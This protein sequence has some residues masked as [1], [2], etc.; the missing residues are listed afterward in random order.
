[1]VEELDILLKNMK[2]NLLDLALE[3]L[4]SIE[5]KGFKAF[6]VGGAVRDYLMGNILNIT[7]VDICSNI[8]DITLNQLFDVKQELYKSYKILFKNSKAN[9]TDK[10][11]TTFLPKLPKYFVI[12]Y[13]VP[14]T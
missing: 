14:F 7:D 5:S 6:I 3:I 2:N 1:M 9:V 11:L 4:D 8:D 10:F 12:L 13:V